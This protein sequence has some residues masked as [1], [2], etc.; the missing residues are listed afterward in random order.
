MAK[1]VRLLLFLTS[2]TC[3]IL[4]LG[5]CKVTDKSL[6]TRP[7]LDSVNT[8]VLDKY[9]FEWE[10]IRIKKFDFVEVRFAGLNPKVTSTL[11]NFGGVDLN[12]NL[13]DGLDRTAKSALQVDK[14]G[15]LNFPL[16]DKV[17][18]EGL[19]VEE[20]RK[21]LLAKIDPLLQD[22]FVYINLPKRSITVLAEGAKQPFVYSKNKANFLEIIAESNVDLY[23]SDLTKVK[24]YRESENGIRTLG[25][26]NLSDTSMFNSE[27]FYPLPNDVIYIPR[28][29]KMA[30]D[31]LMRKVMPLTAL[32]NIVVTLAVLF[33]R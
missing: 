22:P 20:L 26:I 3:A 28:N 6:L 24:I 21:I 25:N 15:Y 30:N 31:E 29:S 1:G 5:S 14:E 9:P 33:T 19:T 11:N 27:Y 7:Y 12:T 32:L 13:A 4:F 17:R 16:I 23:N 2:L 10:E 18:A 8:L